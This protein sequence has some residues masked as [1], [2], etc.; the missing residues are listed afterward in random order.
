MRWVLLTLLATSALVM[1]YGMALAALWSAEWVS[2]WRIRRR[3]I[4]R[5]IEGSPWQ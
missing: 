1:G 4:K 2:R 3:A 5:M